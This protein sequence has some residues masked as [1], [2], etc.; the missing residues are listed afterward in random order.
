MLSGLGQKGNLS[1]D[2]LEEMIEAVDADH[3]KTM[4]FSEFRLLMQRLAED[5]QL[6]AEMQAGFDDLNRL[7]V[8]AKSLVKMTL[9][10]IVF[11]CL[12]GM[13]L[14]AAERDGE[15]SDKLAHS[16]NSIELDRR[17]RALVAQGNASA[18]LV[19]L[20]HDTAGL[21]LTDYDAIPLHEV[22][23]Y[24]DWAFP[25]ATFFVVTLVT[26]V[27]YGAYTPQTDVGRLLTTLLGLCGVAWFGYLLVLVSERVNYTVAV[28]AKATYKRCHAS[29]TGKVEKLE[30]KAKN[31]VKEQVVV[32]LIANVIWISFFSFL[33]GLSGDLEFGNAVYASVITFTTVGLGDYAPPFF[34]PGESSLM[35]KSGLYFVWS[36]GLVFGLALLSSLISALD[37]YGRYEAEL[38][39]QD[40]M[41]MADL[42]AANLRKQMVAQLAVSSGTVAVPVGGLLSGLG[43]GLRTTLAQVSGSTIEDTPVEERVQQSSAAD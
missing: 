41:R 30:E 36:I 21:D 15:L 7:T 38:I 5:A 13:C 16:Q 29:F 33:M 28:W 8:P 23:R 34:S 22:D 14:S 40:L 20:L 37:E 6:E 42:N 31:Q 19:D 9:T 17:I 43:N 2:H 3:N 11:I 27:G 35:F 39:Q 1:K 24:L 12:M 25:G 26:T 10:F 4:D 32:A 18:D